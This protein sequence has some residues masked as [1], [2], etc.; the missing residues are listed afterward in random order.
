MSYNLYI[1][2]QPGGELQPATAEE[3]SRLVQRL[4]RGGTTAG[5]RLAHLVRELE[6]QGDYGPLAQ[7][8]G[9]VMVI[10]LPASDRMRFMR[11]TVDA[12]T[13]QGLTVLDDQLGIVF[14]PGGGVLPGEYVP[15][16]RS[17]QE[18]LDTRPKPL[19]KQA[20]Q[21][22]VIRQVG[23]VLKQHGFERADRTN[24]DAEFMRRFEGGMQSVGLQVTGEGAG[25]QC[26]SYFETQHDRVTDIYQ[27]VCGKDWVFGGTEASLPI[28]L[29]DLLGESPKWR[30]PCA[31]PADIRQLAFTIRQS[32]LPLLDECRD[33]R[34][35]D[36]MVQ[37]D[38]RFAGLQ[39]RFAALIVAALTGTP[40][41]ERLCGRLRAAYA[42]RPQEIVDKLEK[43][44]AH[45]RQLSETSPASP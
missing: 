2:E 32:V 14:T 35:V 40:D 10:A 44:I 8:E 37:C 27:Q 42:D 34:V 43:L 28:S 9:A 41:F 6:R 13:S 30:H 17:V 20:A 38:A 11:L 23:A 16:W 5:R 15:F 39:D 31:T 45:L 21:A 18:E 19:S 4:Q 29:R 7:P 33:L 36:R 1:W 26:S 3:A 22:A 25:R 24:W 12:A